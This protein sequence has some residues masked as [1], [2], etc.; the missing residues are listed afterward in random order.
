MIDGIV[1]SDCEATVAVN[2]RGTGKSDV[3]VKAVI[4]T[5]FNGYLTL[6]SEIIESLGLIS[7][8]ARTAELADGSFIII[9]VY[10]ATI[11]WD[12]HSRAVQVLSAESSPLLGMDLLRGHRLTLDAV[13]G[14]IVKIMQLS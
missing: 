2:V 1:T 14:G 11:Y 10:R 7:Q 13:P 4:D 9:S 6:T 12:G 3:T 5:G 8:G